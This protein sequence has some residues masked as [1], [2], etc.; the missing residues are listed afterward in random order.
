MPPDASDE[1][2]LAFCPPADRFAVFVLARL[3]EYGFALACEE[4]GAW[5]PPRFEPAPRVL[6]LKL[7][8]VLT[9]RVTLRLP[10]V[11]VT[12]TLRLTLALRAKP[13]RPKPNPPRPNPPKVQP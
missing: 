10:T 12:L 13:P 8:L 1:P 7:R 9:V 2:R 4:G 5:A 11:L 6:E 3:W